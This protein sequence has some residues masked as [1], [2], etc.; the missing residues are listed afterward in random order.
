VIPDPRTATGLLLWLAGAGLALA[1]PSPGVGRLKVPPP[2]VPDAELCARLETLR[3]RHALPGL[4]GAVVR[5]NDLAATGAA[6]VRRIDADARLTV[7]DLFHLG[8]CTKAMTATCLAVLV[9]KQKLSWDDT[10]AGVFPKPPDALHPDYRAVTLDQL[11]THRAGVP[12]DGP[13]AELGSGLTPTAQRRNLLATLCSRPPEIRPGKEC[14]Y[15]N[16]GYALAGLMAETRTGV[17]WESLM[18]DELFTPLGMAGCGFGAPGAPG[19][20]DQPLGHVFRDGRWIPQHR[21]NPPALGPAGTVHASLTDWARFVSLHLR[22][23]QHPSRLLTVGTF[24]RMHMPPPEGDYAHGWQVVERP[25]AGGRALT[26]NGTNGLWFS[27]V[28]IAPERDFAVLVVA[29][30][31]GDS[32]AHACDEA[33]GA[34][35][36]WHQ[37]HPPP[38]S[39]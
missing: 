18:R 7:N 12:R 39:P 4:A 5:G 13:W 8:S 29:N 36:D 38:A 16:A 22:G 28:W 2:V 26:H 6:G 27:T 19:S 14:R 25:W 21:D 30:A 15:S 31:G 11:L 17:S 37:K 24:A 34:L 35:I 1:D 9:E 10:L 33:A 32:A 3:A 23:A 20:A